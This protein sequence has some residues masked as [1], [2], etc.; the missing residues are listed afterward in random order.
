[1]FCCKKYNDS[2]QDNFRPRRGVLIISIVNIQAFCNE[3]QGM[4]EDSFSF[5]PTLSSKQVLFSILR[6]YGDY[7]IDASRKRSET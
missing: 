5:G 2:E 7:S 3:F 1:M 4:S 6:V